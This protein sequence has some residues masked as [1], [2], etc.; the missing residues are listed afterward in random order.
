MPNINILIG[1][2]M[3]LTIIVLVIT[4]NKCRELEYLVGYLVLS[5]VFVIWLIIYY[6]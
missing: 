3:F 6:S 5:I 2:W 1:L 4:T